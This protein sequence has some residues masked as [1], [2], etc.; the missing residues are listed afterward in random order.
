MAMWDGE[1]T[2][3]FKTEPI[4]DYP[5]WERV[6]C[7]CCGGIQWGGESPEECDNCEGRGFYCR[8]IKSG[9]IKSWPGGPFI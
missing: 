9:V 6:D 2:I 3:Y 4:E 5:G 1:K 8:H 7:G